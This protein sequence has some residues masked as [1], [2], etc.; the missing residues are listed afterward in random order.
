MLA[1]TAP[2][3]VLKWTAISV[4][5]W[6]VYKPLSPLLHGKSR[7]VCVVKPDAPGCKPDDPKAPDATPG[8]SSVTGR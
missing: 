6:L 1:I 5:G 2:F 7:A 8:G 4:L 3:N